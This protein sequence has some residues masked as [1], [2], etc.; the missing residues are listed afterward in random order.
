ML[1][2]QAELHT[3]GQPY[4]DLYD[5]VVALKR[6][7]D[8]HPC[9]VR[10]RDGLAL[11][12]EGEREEVQ[13]LVLRFRRLP[14][15]TRSRLPALWNSL[16]QLEVVIGDLEASQSD[17]EEVARLVTDP[18]S[19]AEAH[20]NVFRAAVER[21]EW[22]IALAS[23][24]RAVVLDPETFEPF[25]FSRYEPLR[26]L[27]AG[28]FGVSFLCRDR[29]QADRQVVIRALRTDS[30]DRD[31]S[32]LLREARL[33]QEVD[34]P[35]LVRI[36]DVGAMG[37]E[38]PRPYLVQEYIEA[39]TLAEIVA[40]QG[41]LAPEE[42]LQVAWPLLR[43]LQALHGRGLLQRCLRPQSVLVRRGK[44][45]DGANCWNVKLLD[46]GLMF[47][48]SIIH[49]SASNPE[50]LRD[51][52]L[53]RSVAHLI[54]FAPPEVVGR[55]KGQVWVGPHSDLFNLG[56]LCAF[57]LTGKPEPSRADCLLV[58]E[59]WRNL[60]SSCTAW[61]I[62]ARPDHAGA[63]LD[64]LAS[65]LLQDPQI[66]R[67]DRHLHDS[68]LET[69]DARLQQRPDDLDALLQRASAH[70]Q[71]GAFAE[72]LADYTAALQLQPEQA[73]LLRRRGLVQFRA[74]QPA[75]A[76]A[77]FT[78]SLR[79]EPR[80]LDAITQRGLAFAQMNDHGR[81]VADYTEALRLDPH[82]ES[83]FFN[84]G[85][86][87]YSQGEFALAV[88]DYTEALRL[89]PR[90]IWS[91]SNRG[92]A[93]LML[94]DAGRAVTDF[95]RLLQLTPGNV[96]ALCDRA[97][98]Y[99]HLGR[100][101]LAIADYSQ[102]LTLQ[103][104]AGLHHDRGL[105][106][107]STGNLA[108]AVADF[109][110][111]LDLS[112]ENPA[113]LISRGRAYNDLGQTD[114]ALADLTEA[115]R[116][117]PQ[118]TAALL[119][120]AAVHLRCNQLDEALTDLTTLLSLNS[121]PRAFF[122]RGRLHA[123]RGDFARAIEDYTEA[124]RLDPL[125]AS[126]FANRGQAHLRRGSH[127]QA[128]AD[129]SEAIRLEPED[130]DLWLAR[131]ALHHQLGQHAAALADYDAVLKLDPAEIQAAL[132]RA[133]LLSQQGE[134]DRALADLDVVIRLVP[135]QPEALCQ[136]GDIHARRGQ[137]Q[138]AQADF[139]AVLQLAPDYLPARYGRGLT[140]AEAGRF[141]EALAD[142][143][144]VLRLEPGNPSALVNRGIIRR[145]RGEQAEA[146]ADFTT[147]IAAD[148]TYPLGYYNRASL[149]IARGELDQAFSD[150]ELILSRAPDDL[151]ALMMRA[152]IH[153]LRNEPGLALRD[154]ESAL[155]VAPD[156]VRICNNLAWRL[157][158][159]AQAD[160]R[161]PPRALELARQALEKGE[162]AFRLDTLAAAQAANSQFAE[163][164]Q[165]Q[166]KALA[167]VEERQRGEFEARLAL[168]EQSLPFVQSLPAST[169]DEPQ[170]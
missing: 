31:S 94:G 78:E 133:Q 163:A 82:S 128:L 103:P 121:E 169:P 127:D 34:H 79:L 12:S 10:P 80:Q 46:S 89:D 48:R 155:R 19:Q 70:T 28:G 149:L 65:D 40:E 69:L 24:R 106:Q 116:L 143:D 20:H 14:E 44:T 145:H 125:M 37:N 166:R 47:R 152:R 88:A 98:A 8:L 120:R 107:A 97:A 95:T 81:A 17:F 156:D 23:L 59:A 117:A 139:D 72:A 73:S 43:L 75:A 161:N 160:L 1:D 109:S 30:L 66:G 51:S 100:H 151:E 22:E 129:F 136:R 154:N 92:K 58:P 137:A 114:R 63:V 7:H 18:I 39:R 83:L 150:L 6:R 60:I 142:F 45:R 101:A 96:K 113:V 64:R 55:P 123:R 165:T 61:R 85:N 135:D 90:H 71:Q 5:A 132:A 62:Q 4:Q 168:Y 115:L 130:A 74:G 157:A 147:A 36:L 126:T 67:I 38:T 124:I 54:P 141:D 162:D 16:A 104:S 148:P 118:S 3:A 122:E 86:A 84:R 21:R 9:A 111:A 32:L 52:G 68:T 159:T 153:V 76:I 170:R 146:L 140:H 144:H 164:A 105:I 13:D 158:T 110:A 131:A 41:P 15:D 134:F 119:E 35:A 102:A 93:Y 26:L 167:L 33:L 112:L 108:E 99:Q 42:W 56:R 57:G 91:L 25:P 50:A 2:I 53:G 87:H 11:R 29:L 27:G 49:A 77:D 138:K